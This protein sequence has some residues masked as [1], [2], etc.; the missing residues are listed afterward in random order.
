MKGNNCITIGKVAFC[1]TKTGSPCGPCLPIRKT[2][3]CIANACP[4]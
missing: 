3:V 1:S 4:K 2:G